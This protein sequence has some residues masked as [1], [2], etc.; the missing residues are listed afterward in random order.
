MKYIEELSPG[1]CFSFKDSYWIITIDFKNNGKRLCY[2]LES[3]NPSWFDAD[4]IVDDI[5]IYTMDEKNVIIPIKETQKN[6]TT[7]SINI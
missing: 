5:Q 1:E 2:N 4:T 3:G 7:K 6:A